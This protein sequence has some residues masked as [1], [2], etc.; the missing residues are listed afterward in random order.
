MDLSKLVMLSY[1]DAGEHYS[2]DY[3]TYVGVFTVEESCNRASLISNS[4]APQGGD[5]NFSW[6]SIDKFG[7]FNQNNFTINAYRV[8][9]INNPA[10]NATTTLFDL[11]SRNV[12][13]LASNTE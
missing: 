2:Y 8:K 10:N 6:T 11:V 3:P 4:L 7:D 1:R 5:V 13:L 12:G 9:W